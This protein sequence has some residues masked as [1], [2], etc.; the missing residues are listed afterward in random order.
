MILLTLLMYVAIASCKSIIDKAPDQIKT[1]LTKC[2]SYEVISNQ[3]IIGYAVKPF[4]VEIDRAEE[5]KEFE[6]KLKLKYKN[7]FNKD[8]RAY[9]FT[10]DIA[11]DTILIT[12][13]LSPKQIENIPAWKC[14]L[15]DVDTYPKRSEIVYYNS[16]KNRFKIPGDPD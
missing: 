5:I 1:E 12:S 14:Q 9:S 6:K 10:T 15:L 8:L 2:G 13:F 16:S 7:K 11:G 3:R 4:I